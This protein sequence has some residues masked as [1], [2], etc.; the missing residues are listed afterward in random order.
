M[1][2]QHTRPP[3]QLWGGVEPTINRVGDRY[4]RQFERNGHRERLSDL[5]E[6]A[7]LGLRTLRF[8]IL[9]EE[10]APESLEV[11]DWTP[12]DAA[13]QKLRELGIR[14]IA[15]LLHHGSGPRYTSLVDPEFPEKL[16]RFARTVAERYPWIDAYTPVNEPLT[17]ARFSGLYGHWYPHGKDEP[18]FARCL[19]NECRGVVLAMQEI[20]RVNP[21]AELVQTDDLGKIYSTPKL[22]YQAEY[23]NERRWLTW[24]LLAGRIGPE[25]AM[26]SPLRGAGISE[27][28]LASFQENPCPPDIIGINH[29]ITSERFLDDNLAAHP[30]DTHGGNGR[31][32]YAD[33]AAVRVRREG[34]G[35]AAGVLAEAWQRYGLPLAITEAHI[36]CT[37]EEQLRWFMEVWR[38]AEKLR[39]SG[40]DARAVTVWSLLGAHDWNSLLTRQEGFYEPG[41]FDLRGGVLRPTAI[42]RMVTE[43]AN[44]RSFEHP[45][46]ENAGW[47][48]RSVRLGEPISADDDAGSSL[49]DQCLPH[50]SADAKIVPAPHSA[51]AQKPIL[52]TGGN[53]RL[54]QGF[55]RAAEVRGL[56]YRVLSR[57]ELD[58]AEPAEVAAAIEALKPWAIINCAGYSGVDDAE[59]D[60]HA[61]LRSNTDGAATLAAACAQHSI[62]LV[63]FSSDHV[64]DGAKREPYLE[65]DE[66]CPLS[67]YG[68][69]KLLAER[70][71]LCRFPA[72]LVIRAG[73]VF[74]PLEDDDF[75][76][77]NLRAIA[78]GERVVVANDIRVSGTYLPDLVQ[79]ALDLLVDGERGIWHLANTGAVTPAQFL[80]TAADISRLD[81]GRI[82][83]IPDWRLNRPARRPAYRVLESERGQLLPALEDAIQRYCRETPA[84][85]EQSEELAA[86]S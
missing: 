7:A 22:H 60:E 74:A 28:E 24:D 38:G 33:V 29:Y 68:E 3:L 12:V 53:G 46:L 30:P 78:R 49:R 79:A 21:G 1:T 45:T 48:R 50:I 72:A 23:E 26:W 9:W 36:G 15:G 86:S 35:G 69:S 66:P 75:L 10:I 54:A 4:F 55:I 61:C 63:T 82:D 58:V 56:A 31:D 40:I 19:I 67:V 5:E 34:I 20:R 27:H 62:A 80:M 2:N 8:P 18:T 37:R 16:A 42:A 73:K 47:W 85:L 17:T 70:E 81:A 77:R 52:I 25:G 44:S 76:R 32:A 6:F 39:A 71:V 14:P 84:I 65:R 11:C 59:S 13:L 43:L 41:A 57:A 83:G 64:F 51:G